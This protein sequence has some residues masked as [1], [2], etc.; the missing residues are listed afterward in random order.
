MINKIQ[1]VY[2]VD[3]KSLKE[4][5]SKNSEK[6]LN[7]LATKLL[8][9]AIENASIEFL[10]HGDSISGFIFVMGSGTSINSKIITRNDSLIIKNGTAESFLLLTDS[11]LN[12]YQPLTGYN[13][14]LI[15]TDQTKLSPET[16]VAIS[17]LKEKE[18]EE[19]EF[20]DNLGK[21]QIGNYVDEFG[22]NIN[23]SYAYSF[24]KG[25]HE[26]SLAKF[27]DVYVKI[28]KQESGL[29]FDIYN[30]AL[31]MK[32]SLP[33]KEFGMLKIKYPDGSVVSEKVFLTD[34]TLLEAPDDKNNLI[35]NHILANASPLKIQLDLSTAS[36]YYT[37]KYVFEL[38]QNNL[39]PILQEID[40][41]KK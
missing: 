3:K 40:K 27:S 2:K 19:K 28:M 31:T 36:S 9:A 37:D 41:S 38:E 12:L 11:G 20:N 39:L 16:E 10:I 25:S 32:E 29:F 22:D 21:W 24:V 18:K 1:G 26:N 8:D 14:S 30:D 4:Q 23:Q 34:N 5:I 17:N 33:D 35:Y 7:G 6:E 15:K 13:F